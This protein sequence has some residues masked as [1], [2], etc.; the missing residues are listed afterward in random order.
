ML[1]IY[2]YIKKKSFFRNIIRKLTWKI[3][4]PFLNL[5]TR[6]IFSNLTC[7]GE[8]SIYNGLLQWRFVPVVLL[9]DVSSN[10][11]EK[12]LYQMAASQ[13]KM[14]AKLLFF[15]SNLVLSPLL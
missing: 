3:C 11:K 12:K 4:D 8:N 2:I 1:N 5:E 14:L 9:V 6:L 10:L 15:L 7:L 13:G